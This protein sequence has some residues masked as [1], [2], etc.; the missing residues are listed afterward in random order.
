MDDP[1]QEQ[2]AEG[3]VNHGLRDVDALLVVRTL[4]LVI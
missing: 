2:A 4:K 1:A 3:D